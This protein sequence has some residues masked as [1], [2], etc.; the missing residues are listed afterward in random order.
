MLVD[1]EES[2]INLTKNVLTLYNQLPTRDIVYPLGVFEVTILPKHDLGHTINCVRVLVDI[3]HNTT[4]TRELSHLVDNFIRV[5]N[6]VSIDK[7][8]GKMHSIQN[9]PTQEE[10]LSRVQIIYDYKYIGGY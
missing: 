3:W 7:F 4:N 1:F 8:Y 9:I 6:R 5:T 2:F 10:N